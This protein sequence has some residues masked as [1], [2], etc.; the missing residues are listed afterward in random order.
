V[1][2]ENVTGAGGTIGAGRVARAVPNG[3]TLLVGLWNTHVANGALYNLQYDVVND[4][5]P[6]ALTS[7]YSALYQPSNCLIDDCPIA[8]RDGGDT[9]RLV[10]ELLPGFTH[11][12]SPH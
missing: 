2:I 6:V 8:G 1:I 7:T 5:E 11:S 12:K 10:E 3:Y 9:A 4:F